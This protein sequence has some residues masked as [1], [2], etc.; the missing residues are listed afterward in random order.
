[1]MPYFSAASLVTL[2]QEVAACSVIFQ[3]RLFLKTK[4]VL[5]QSGKLNFFSL[6]WPCKRVNIFNPHNISHLTI[7]RR[8][9]ECVTYQNCCGILWSKSCS[10]QNRNGNQ[11]LQL[12][13][14]LAVLYMHYKKLKTKQKN[15]QK[16]TKSSQKFYILHYEILSWIRKWN[17]VK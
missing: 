8:S 7:S 13:I 3:V 9:C 10:A 1:M 5:L 11:H 16:Y 14:T 6:F 17:Q 15:I 4:I 2:D 12:Q